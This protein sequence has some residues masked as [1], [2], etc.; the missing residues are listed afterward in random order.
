M[1]NNERQYRIT[2]TEAERF[3]QRERS[4]RRRVELTRK[5]FIPGWPKPSAFSAS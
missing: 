1:I 2:K 4:L 3:K 5:A